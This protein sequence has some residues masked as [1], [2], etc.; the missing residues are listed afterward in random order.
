MQE[1]AK[2]AK[3]LDKTYK[4]L[5]DIDG[6]VLSSDFLESAKNL[7]LMKE[8]IEGNEDAYNQLQEAANQDILAHLKFAP[9]DM[10]SFYNELDNVK[11]LLDK[12][13]FPDLDVGANLDTGNFL[14]SLTDMI[15]AAHMTEEEATAY[16]ANMGI[17]AEVTKVPA[18]TEQVQESH[19]YWIPATYE[20]GEMDT[21]GGDN[22]KGTFA[23]PKVQNPGR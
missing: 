23:Y 20:K 21:G 6:D 3:E 10:S 9:E 2:A 17:D 16:L 7:D 4:N 14:Q 8:A 1:A 13:N 22:A 11:S 18:E 19:S 15:N 5:L 12:Q